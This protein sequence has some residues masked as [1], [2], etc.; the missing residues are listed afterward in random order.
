MV[1]WHAVWRAR[2]C[3]LPHQSPNCVHNSPNGV[4]CNHKPPNEPKWSVL[5]PPDQLNRALLGVLMWHPWGVPTPRLCVCVLLVAPSARMQKIA[6]CFIIKISRYTT[7]PFGL[8]S[9]DIPQREL[10]CAA[11]SCGGPT[12]SPG[13]VMSDVAPHTRNRPAFRLCMA[14]AGLIKGQSA[15]TR[16]EQ[17]P[18]APLRSS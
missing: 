17:R 7:P 2:H 1:V 15:Q 10:A 8:M 6:G 14:H 11:R 3:P 4:P 16:T 5:G 13:F 12:A 18:V 9:A